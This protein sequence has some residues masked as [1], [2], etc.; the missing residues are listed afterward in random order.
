MCTADTKE[1][2][3]GSLFLPSS[4]SLSQEER[5][6]EAAAGGHMLCLNTRFE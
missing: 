4:G 6:Q 2:A 5:R 3:C 1:L